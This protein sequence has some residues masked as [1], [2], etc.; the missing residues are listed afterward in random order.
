LSRLCLKAAVTAS[1]EAVNIYKREGRSSG[2]ED[3]GFLLGFNELS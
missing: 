3:S 1:S 2:Q